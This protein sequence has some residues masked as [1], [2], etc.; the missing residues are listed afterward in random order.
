MRCNSKQKRAVVIGVFLLTGIFLTLADKSHS[1]G[2]RDPMS[3]LVS[4]NGQILIAIDDGPSDLILQ[5][6]L[7]SPD[8]ASVIIS[9]EI[10]KENDKIYDYLVEKISEKQVI[11]V[12]DNEKIVLKLEEE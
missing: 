12:N 6:I 3:P 10:L 11:L 2:Q 5:G 7:Y 9:G 1:Q 8:S 4:I